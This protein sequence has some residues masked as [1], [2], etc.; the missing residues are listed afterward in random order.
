M[1]VRGRN[2]E[3]EKEIAKILYVREKLTLKEIAEK[4]GVQ[5]ATI[6]GWAEREQW[7]KLRSGLTLCKESIIMD[8]Y[9]QIQ[10]ITKTI[11]ERPEGM[12]KPTPNEATL[13]RKLSESVKNME[14]DIGIAEIVSCGM[15]FIDF[16]RNFEYEKSKEVAPLW[17]SFLRSKLQKV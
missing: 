16:L 1:A 11:S 17:D 4:V 14:Q 2:A 13:I 15:Q 8:I 6:I 7:A 10:D 12:R 5:E 3:K 9:M